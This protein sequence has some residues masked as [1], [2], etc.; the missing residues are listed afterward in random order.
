MITVR[1][2][3]GNSNLIGL[4]Y[5]SMLGCGR[6]DKVF[7]AA[8]HDLQ[9]VLDWSKDITIIGAFKDDVLIGTG[10]V[11]NIQDFTGDNWSRR[12]A[13]VG[14]GFLPNCSIF[15]SLRAGREILDIC[16]SKDGLG[17]DDMFGTTPEPNKQAVA[18]I[19]R[20]GLALYGPIPNFTN[21][22]GKHVGVYTSYISREQWNQQRSKQQ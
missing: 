4:W 5:L 15:E 11:N 2:I 14:F 10:F 19:R 8:P 13:E 12:R 3:S 17:I 18:Y 16:F 9:Y 1:D 6:A 7:Y 20:I 21:Y 22:L